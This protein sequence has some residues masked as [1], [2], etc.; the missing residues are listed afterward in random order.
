MNID[1]SGLDVAN[2][3]LTSVNVNKAGKTAV[4]L[5]LLQSHMSQHSISVDEIMVFDLCLTP[6]AKPSADLMGFNF[7]PQKIKV[8]NTIADVLHQVRGSN[9]L[10]VVINN[11]HYLSVHDGRG[12]SSDD[13][14]VNNLAE[15]FVELDKIGRKSKKQPA[16]F[17]TARIDNGK[18]H[19]NQNLQKAVSMFAERG[20]L[21]NNKGPTFI[22]EEVD[23]KKIFEEVT[24][25]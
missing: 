16:L 12:H 1:L 25:K 15:V 11:L 8:V 13:N 22:P 3:I 24:K 2:K 5:G 18:G 10:G 4:A 6:G 20:T 19:C 21:G 9:T 7:D 23:V 14:I 17:A